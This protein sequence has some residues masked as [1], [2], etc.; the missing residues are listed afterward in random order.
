MTLCHTEGGGARE[1]VRHTN[2]D[3]IDAKTEI[4][5]C[6]VREARG[7]GAGVGVSPL[8]AVAS[9]LFAPRSCSRTWEEG[10]VGGRRPGRTHVRGRGLGGG[11]SMDGA[12]ERGGVHSRVGGFIAE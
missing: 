12:L 5:E 8:P 4:P 7:R 1:G 3:G 10:K 2:L 11:L 9:V 6:G